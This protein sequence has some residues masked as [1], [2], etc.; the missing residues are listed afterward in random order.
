MLRPLPRRHGPLRTVAFLTAVCACLALPAAAPAAEPFVP[1]QSARAFGESTGV[2]VR[3]TWTTSAYGRYDTIIA[4][5]AE[6]GVRN[7]R[8]GLCPTCTYQTDA[9]NRLARLGIRSN[10]GI[11]T[12]QNGPTSIP[13]GL[14]GIRE[15]L[16]RGSVASIEAPNEPDISGVAD[17]IP[18]TRAFQIE[19][20]RQVNADPAVSAIPVL[21]PSLVNPASRG[22]LGNLSGHLDRGNIHPYSGGLP[23]LYNI[24]SEKLL[25]SLVSGAKPVVATEAGFHTDLALGGGHHG[26]TEEVVAVY[27]PRIFLEAFRGGIERTYLFQLADPWTDA[28]AIRFGGSL[29]ENSFGLLRHNLAPKPSFYALRNLLR[30]V[31]AASAPVASPGGLRLSLA[32]AGP[33]VQRLLLRAA[34]GT[35]ALVLWRTVSIWDRNADRKLAPAP[36]RL[37]V[38]LGDPIASASRFDPVGSDAATRSWSRPQRI[39]VDLAGAPVVLRLKPAA[40]VLRRLAPGAGSEAKRAARRQKLCPAAVLGPRSAASSRRAARGR[41]CLKG[42]RARKRARGTRRSVTW[43]Q[44]SKCAKPRKRAK[45]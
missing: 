18:K 32:G 12:L 4:R 11:G 28:D 37:E 45:R 34:D 9:L 25:A 15:K 39:P 29:S 8:D 35:Y 30:S 38:V 31:N 10:L 5:L 16:L 7:V 1:A 43:S 27:T 42:Q 2:N 3:L 26:A 21:G 22:Q 6:L 33:D 41:C 36:D 20:F 13:A 19:L 24:G 23:P 17:W 44:A 40:A 14:K